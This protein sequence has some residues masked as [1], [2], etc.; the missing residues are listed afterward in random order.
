MK[1]IVCGLMLVFLGGVMGS[2]S[3]DSVPVPAL[4]ATGAT[5]A[6][7][8][9]SA[10]FAYELAQKTWCSN[11]DAC[12]MVLLMVD[13]RDNC[14]NFAQRLVLLKGRGIMPG[15]WNPAA[16][17]TVD[18]GT[19]AYMVYRA[20]G[21]KGGL[22][23]RLL[24]GRRYAYR[25]AVDRELMQRGSEDELLTGPEVVGIMG[26]AAQLRKR[27]QQIRRMRQRK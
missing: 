16:E 10:S 26:R 27:E 8:R 22:M 2:C 1:W 9:D 12:S 15:D 5:S 7:Q 19:L 25:E 18:K 20:L 3:M 4:K 23:M 24:P 6:P 21:L 11:D 14:E 13:G 17:A